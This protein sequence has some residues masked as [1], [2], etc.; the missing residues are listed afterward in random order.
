MAW[1]WLVSKQLAH[2]S[3]GYLQ[4]PGFILFQCCRCLCIPPLCRLLQALRI[5]VEQRGGFRPY[6]RR[7]ALEISFCWYISQSA[8]DYVLSTECLLQGAINKKLSRTLAEVRR[9]NDCFCML[10]G[11]WVAQFHEGVDL[12]VSPQQT[13]REASLYSLST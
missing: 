6:R 12:S 10:Q 13:P 7:T 5:D 9:T 3:Q 8:Y 4:T 1:S 11:A 2:F